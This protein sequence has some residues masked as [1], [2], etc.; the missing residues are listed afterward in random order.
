MGLDQGAKRKAIV[1]DSAQTVRPPR[2]TI[3][4]AGQQACLEVRAGGSDPHPTLLAA[5]VHSSGQHGP[6]IE[7]TGT[8]PARRRPA[9]QVSSPV[10]RDLDPRAAGTTPG[11]PCPGVG[12]PTTPAAD[13]RRQ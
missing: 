12:K 4:R 8:A 7:S 11:Q 10:Y 2:H 3:S 6:R 5:I 9:A 13:K 1:S